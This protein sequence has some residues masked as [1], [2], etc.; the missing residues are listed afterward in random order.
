MATTHGQCPPKAA[1]LHQLKSRRFSVDTPLE[2]AEC[3]TGVVIG[4]ESDRVTVLFG[5]Y[6][7]RTLS[8]EA[9]RAR[10]KNNALRPQSSA[11]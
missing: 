3:G 4:G 2:H 10:D 1:H 11:L 7:Y 6:G 9:I 5:Q 8:R